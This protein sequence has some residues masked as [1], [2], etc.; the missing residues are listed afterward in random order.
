MD[1][2]YH[3]EASCST[4]FQIGNKF[5]LAPSVIHHFFKN[6][7]TSEEGFVTKLNTAVREVEERQGSAPRQRPRRLKEECSFLRFFVLEIG[8]R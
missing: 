7:L 4:P 6:L 2:S 3:T 5:S 8:N 1:G